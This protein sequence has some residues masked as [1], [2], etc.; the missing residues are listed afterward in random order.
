MVFD[1]INFSTNST[2]MNDSG[3]QSGPR[4]SKEGHMVEDLNP[5]K[6]ET[7]DTHLF[8]QDQVHL[9]FDEEEEINDTG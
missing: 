5:K 6:K 8:Q 1:L 7:A 4:K 9:K 2:K 3:N